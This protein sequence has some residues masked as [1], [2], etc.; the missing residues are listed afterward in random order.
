MHST[1][2][3]LLFLESTEP[4]PVEAIPSDCDVVGE[5]EFRRVLCTPSPTAAIIQAADLQ[6]HYQYEIKGYIDIVELEL[7]TKVEEGTQPKVSQSSHI[8]TQS[9]SSGCSKSLKEKMRADLI[10]KSTQWDLLGG[11]AP[12]SIYI[13]EVAMLCSQRSEVETLCEP[14]PGSPLHKIS[15]SGSSLAQRQL[16][17][18]APLA[19]EYARLSPITGW[20]FCCSS[21]IE[22]LQTDQQ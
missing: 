12:K 2:S 5:S 1:L 22:Q 11:L 6:R 15:T 4:L 21:L 14:V 16:Q 17:H 19:E 18:P 20:R 3:C 7:G 10:P 9:S 13:S 8:Q